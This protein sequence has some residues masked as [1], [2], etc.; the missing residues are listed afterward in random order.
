MLKSM[1]SLLPNPTNNR[2]CRNIY[3]R[4]SWVP[5]QNMMHDNAMMSEDVKT[6]IPLVNLSTGNVG[7]WI[8]HKT[9]VSNCRAPVG[10][11]SSTSVSSIT[12][13]FRRC[14][15]R[16]GD[17]LFQSARNEVPTTSI[18]FISHKTR[19]GT[20]SG[21]AIFSV[22]SVTFRDCLGIFSVRSEVPISW[23]RGIILVGAI[24][25]HSHG[26]GDVVHSHSLAGDVVHSHG[27]WEVIEITSWRN[28]HE[29]RQEEETN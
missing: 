25:V 28:I 26:S 2:I 13:N 11:L 7:G 20:A 10:T 8:S 21:Q 16:N 1:Y 15:C 5:S 22:K 9:F 12:F 6:S 3:R 23:S 4:H 18:V 27:S 19:A 17:S 24:V 14:L 29:H